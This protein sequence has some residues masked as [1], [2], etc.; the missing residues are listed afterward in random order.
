MPIDGWVFVL[1]E[2]ENGIVRKLYIGWSCRGFL[3]S[4][5]ISVKDKLPTHNEWVLA[6]DGSKMGVCWADISSYDYLFMFGMDST[7]QFKRVT[8]WMPLPEPPNE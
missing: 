5:W 1:L 7:Q 2:I 8:Y 4:Q 6:F 3:M